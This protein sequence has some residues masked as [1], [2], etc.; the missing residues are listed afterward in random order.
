MEIKAG[1]GSSLRHGSMRA[2]PDCDSYNNYTRQCF[3]AYT[4]H[5]AHIQTC[6]NNR[7]VIIMLII[8]IQG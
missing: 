5:T 6:V 8:T 7:R 3:T 2:T 1:L 4:A